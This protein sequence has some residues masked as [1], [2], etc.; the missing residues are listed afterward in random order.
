M[1][2][3]T[4]AAPIPV[5]PLSVAV[6]RAAR[7]AAFIAAEIAIGMLMAPPYWRDLGVPRHRG[8]GAELTGAAHFE[9][10]TAENALLVSL[11]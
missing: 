3:T 8:D 7:S 1:L 5:T 4:I 9:R 2:A 10:L 11:C 6:F